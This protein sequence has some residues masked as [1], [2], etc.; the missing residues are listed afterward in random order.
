[1]LL[2]YKLVLKKIVAEQV[3][4]NLQYED[5]RLYLP[6]EY[7]RLNPFTSETGIKDYLQYIGRQKNS[8][9]GKTPQ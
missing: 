1:M 7:D 8:M 4:E 6:S 9:Q 3:E 2:P 5:N